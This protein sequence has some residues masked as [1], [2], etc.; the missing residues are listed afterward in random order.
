MTQENWKG[1]A[2]R[3]FWEGKAEKAWVDLGNPPPTPPGSKTPQTQND[4]NYDAFRHAYTSANWTRQ[5]GEDAARAG[6][7]DIERSNSRN[8]LSEK[9]QRD[10]RG[11]LLN[12]EK[13]REIGKNAP[14][15]WTDK[16]LAEE[17]AGALQRGELI[18]DKQTDP[19]TLSENFP[20][21]LSPKDWKEIAEDVW[22][23]WVDQIEKE[24]LERLRD[25]SKKISDLLSVPDPF[26]AAQKW[27][28]RVDPM[29]LDLDGDGI[30]T[31]A[32]S[33]SNPI[34]FDHDG[35]GI[36]NGTGWIKS[37]DGFL[38]LDRNGN[39]LIDNGTELFGDSTPLNAGGKA[40][41]GFA[42][43]VDQD[44][45]QDGKVNAQ[46]ANWNNLK[47]WRDLNQDGISQSA[48]LS[49]LAALGINGLNTGKTANSQVL[50]NGNEIADLGTYTKTDGSV[51]T[52]GEVSRMADVNLFDDTFHREFPDQIP[53]AAGVENLP[54]MQ[55]SGKVRDLREAASQSTRVKDLLTQY[56]AATTREAQF[57]LLDQLLD[58]WADTSGLKEN[59]KD[60][61]PSDYSFNYAMIGN[62]RMPITTGP[63]GTGGDGTTGNVGTIGTGV[64]QLTEAQWGA[65]TAAWQQQMHILEA[66]NGRYFFELP[67]E[68]QTSLSAVSGVTIKAGSATGGGG[69]S[70]VG[71]PTPPGVGL[72]FSVAQKDLLD[73]SYAELKQSVYESLLIQT[74]FRPVLDQ[75]DLI[76]DDAGVRLDFTASNNIFK[77]KS[78]A[79]PSVGLPI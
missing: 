56:S 58:A 3:D 47:I 66:F 53:L 44:T 63:N 24:I 15:D 7:D 48:E 60:R 23:R 16:Q 36:K 2:G 64:P 38:V 51:A 37:D 22:D 11:D 74:R 30:E 5:V 54:D 14:D 75:L 49:T 40:V 68:N 35:D 78:A 76:I 9:G 39:G 42:A 79:I 55:G 27:I 71:V 57:A 26:N 32:P 19:R 41:D 67:G 70:V 72:S 6:G 46:D 59:P 12:N 25:L 1:P 4:F 29:V 73:Q 21:D 61:L 18:T 8:F 31:I 33:S 17:I 45:N 28:L 13:G 50:P 62:D 69:G 77:R 52:L 20:Q 10:M 34:L 65:I 43:L